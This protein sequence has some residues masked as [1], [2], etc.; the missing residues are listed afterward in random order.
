MSQI[1]NVKR[2]DKPKR[3]G[4]VVADSDNEG[5]GVEDNGAVDVPIVILWVDS[6]SICA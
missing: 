6:L 3:G 4:R 2:I 5:D 1:Q